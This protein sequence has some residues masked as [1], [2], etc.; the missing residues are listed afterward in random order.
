[1]RKDGEFYDKQLDYYK[2]KIWCLKGKYNE[3]EIILN[4]TYGY[5]IYNYNDEST[6][7]ATY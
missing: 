5:N 4:N 2:E 6:R 1:M 7:E 3:K